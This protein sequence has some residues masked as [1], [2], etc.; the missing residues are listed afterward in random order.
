M[1]DGKAPRIRIAKDGPYVVSGRVPIVR[2]LIVSAPDG[3]SVGWAQGETVTDGDCALCLSL[4]H[5]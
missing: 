5:I 3:E 2:E 1:D 4:I